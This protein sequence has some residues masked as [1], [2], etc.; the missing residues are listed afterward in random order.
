MR[1]LIERLFGRVHT[2]TRSTIE[3]LW[4]DL[5]RDLVVESEW[6]DY[7]SRAQPGRTGLAR[8]V[9]A[10]K[11]SISKA[12][13][14]FLNSIRGSGGLILV[15]VEE[16]DRL[17]VGFSPIPEAE[18]SYEQMRSWL[19]A[20]LQSVPSRLRQ[21]D[22][23]VVQVPTGAAENIFLIEVHPKERAAVY[24]S[25]GLNQAFQRRMDSSIPLTLPEVLDLVRLRAAPRLWLDFE[26]GP[27]T[28]G[29]NGIDIMVSWRNEGV[30]PARDITGKIVV[31]A[32]RGLESAS[33]KGTHTAS[34]RLRDASRFEFEFSAG[35]PPTTRPVYPGI[36]IGVGVIHIPPGVAGQIRLMTQIWESTGMTEQRHEI[37]NPASGPAVIVE[38]SR[39]HSGYT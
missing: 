15:G 39:T 2:L 19:Q 26:V 28:S 21:I 34:V 3:R 12:A 17:P 30:A 8:D 10:W 6:L 24:Y 18:Q 20:D 31:F 23:E 11:E 29:G 9:R 38:T 7:K 16:E 36:K 14:A 4:G 13:V 22:L 1:E 27:P 5:D 32:E 37:T 33:F 35:M 25:A